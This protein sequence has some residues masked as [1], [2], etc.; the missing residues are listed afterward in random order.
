MHEVKAPVS[1]WHVVVAPVSAVKPNDAL[2][3]ALGP[4]GPLVI[5][6]AGAI[7]STV[8]ERVSVALLPA[9]SVARTVNVWEPCARLL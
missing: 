6:T 7:V 5:V 9:A 4:V 3:L 8:N 2:V 1:I